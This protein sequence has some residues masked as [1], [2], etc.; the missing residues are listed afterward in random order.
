MGEIIKNIEILS[1]GSTLRFSCYW[2][3]TWNVGYM[4]E[5]KNDEMRRFIKQEKESIIEA[6]TRIK[7]M[8]R[9]VMRLMKGRGK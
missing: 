2:A 3:L 4:L 6:F 5:S 9:D 8:N 7:Q 1:N